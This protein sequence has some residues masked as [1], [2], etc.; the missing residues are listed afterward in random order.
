LVFI[1][2]KMNRLQFITTN[3]ADAEK[4]CKGGLRWVQLRVKNKPADE[5]QAI[6][7][8]TKKVCTQYGAT[9]IVND[10]V[11]IAQS[12]GADGVHLGKEDMQPNEARKILGNNFIV[13]GTANTLD[14]VRRLNEMKVD[15][16]GLGP[17]RFTNTKA[18][19][20][21]LL[22]LNGYTEIMQQCGAENL[23]IPVIAIGGIQLSDIEVLMQTGVQ[24]LAVSSAIASAENI[25][26]AA[27]SFIEKINA[28]TK[29]EKRFAN[30]SR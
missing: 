15:Y 8:E 18:N 26:A 5:W 27:R 7:L 13:G 29:N 9:F 30:H 25:E 28:Y 16:I 20:S 10:N 12:V 11:Q 23:G 14:D 19:L 24:G 6:A 17:Y 1:I 3:A 22:G 21:P 2:T 4:A